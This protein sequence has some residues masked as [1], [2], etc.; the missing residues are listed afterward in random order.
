MTYTTNFR[1]L[2][3]SLL[4]GL[5]VEALMLAPLAYFFYFDPDHFGRY[6]HPLDAIDGLISLLIWCA[7]WIGRV[8]C[9]L[10]GAFGLGG[11]VWIMLHRAGRRSWLYAASLGFGAS[12]ICSFC[13]FLAA[14]NRLEPEAITAFAVASTILGLIGAVGWAIAWR[15]AYRKAATATGVEAHF[16]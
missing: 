13:W 4:V 3:L 12:F 10:A 16:E 6:L 9:L 2:C 1:R 8:G 5:L 14:H 15:V 7:V 11:I